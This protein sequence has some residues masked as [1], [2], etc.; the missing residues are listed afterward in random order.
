MLTVDYYI[1]W[2]LRSI[3]FQMRTASPHA[4]PHCSVVKCLLSA[5]TDLGEYTSLL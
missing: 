5:R 4:V 1:K 3:A 2:V